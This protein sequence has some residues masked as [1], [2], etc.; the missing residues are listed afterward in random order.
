MTE[1]KKPESE[2]EKLK[3]EELLTAY[4]KLRDQTEW[5]EIS[6]EEFKEKIKI[7]DKMIVEIKRRG[8]L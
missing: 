3:D 2:F 8:L 7:Q 6:S 5:S 4:L 1:K